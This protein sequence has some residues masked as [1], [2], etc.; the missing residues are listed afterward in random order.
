MKYHAEWAVSAR[1]Q[2]LLMGGGQP[3][4]GQHPMLRHRVTSAEDSIDPDRPAVV[5]SERYT[6]WLLQEVAINDR[7]TSLG[8]AN[9]E[10]T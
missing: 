1:A 6:A 5:P 2:V 9:T 4:G 8:W 3:G 7:K 10:F